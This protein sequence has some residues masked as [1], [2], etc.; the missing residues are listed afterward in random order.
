[1]LASS[2]RG[3]S[4]LPQLGSCLE[5]LA[6]RRGATSSENWTFKRLPAGSAHGARNKESPG[7]EFKPHVGP[8]KIEKKERK[9]KEEE[10]EKDVPLNSPT[11]HSAG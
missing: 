10:T 4:H 9:K 3:R 8:E 2:G 11:E 7:P 5:R 1:M 6:V